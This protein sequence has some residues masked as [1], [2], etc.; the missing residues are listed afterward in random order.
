M[1]IIKEIEFCQYVHHEA[2][3]VEIEEIT[4]KGEKNQI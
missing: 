1:S 2:L 3:Y 4:R